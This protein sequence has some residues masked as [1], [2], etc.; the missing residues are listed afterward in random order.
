VGVGV[1]AL[2]WG[3]GARHT[4]ALWTFGAASFVLAVVAIEFWKGTRAR[5]RIEGEGVLPAF[6]HLIARNRR[7]WGGYIVH[8]GIV[9]IFMG[10][11]GSAWND[12]LKQTLQPGE[13]AEITSPF[14]HTWTLT[15]EGISSGLNVFDE[16]LAWQA[17]ALLSI[18]LDGEAVGTM[19]TEKRGYIRPDGAVA[20]EVGIR[21][22]L[23]EDLYVI[24]AD[25][26]LRRV[27]GAN[28]PSAQEATFTIL[29][30][31]LVNWIWAGTLVM[32]LGCLIALWPSGDVVRAEPKT[33]PAAGAAVPAGAA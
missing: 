27:V 3:L 2:L 21:S 18:D 33:Q 29:I 15:Y 9:L 11:A 16:N 4:M 10:F 19:T 22:L 31:P 32:T 24:L 23:L 26:D 7:R 28:D 8:V 30:K 12:E 17:V 20:T 13:A 6:Y 5:A 25:A 14:G 1:V